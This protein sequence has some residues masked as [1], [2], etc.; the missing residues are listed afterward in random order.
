M[1]TKKIA[2]LHPLSQQILQQNLKVVAFFDNYN[3][4]QYAGDMSQRSTLILVTLQY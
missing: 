1:I 3:A 4:V 2:F